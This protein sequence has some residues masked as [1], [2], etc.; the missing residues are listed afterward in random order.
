M[1][2]DEAI[3]YEN[4][5]ADEMLDRASECRQSGNVDAVKSCYDQYD[6]HKQYAEWFKL[7]REKDND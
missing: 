6:R 4:K 7:L 1:T 3:E 2:L 5:C